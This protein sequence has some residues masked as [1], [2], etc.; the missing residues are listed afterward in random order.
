[1][2]KNLTPEQIA[3]RDAR[4][5]KFRA[6]WRQVAAM[7]ELERVQMGNRLGLLTVDGHSL[8]TCNQI[9]VGMQLPTASVVGGFR[10]WLCHGRAVRKDEHGA[11]IW[12]PTGGRRN[13]VPLDGGTSNSAIVDCQPEGPSDTRFLIGTVFDISQTQ[14]VTP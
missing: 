3:A 13:D 10:Q 2:K 11:M 14:E 6:L 7:P 5:A 1:M 8:S 9:L 12:V 4:K